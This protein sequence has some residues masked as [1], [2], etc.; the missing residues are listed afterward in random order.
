VDWNVNSDRW[1][2][3][4]SWSTIDLLIFILSH[5][6]LDDPHLFLIWEYVSWIFQEY[7]QPL[8]KAPDI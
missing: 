7:P 6:K 3:L 2:C 5:W 4:N 1:W 8:S